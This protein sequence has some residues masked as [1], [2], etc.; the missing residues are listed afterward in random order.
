VH[1]E[2]FTRRLL[3]LGLLCFLSAV[4]ALLG[5]EPL[6]ASDSETV[7]RALDDPRARDLLHCSI[8]PQAPR[9]DFAFRFEVGYIVWCPLASFGGHDSTILI[10][11]RATPDGGKPM[12]LGEGY[13]LPEIDWTTK[14]KDLKQDIQM[15][16]GF[17]V[18]EGQYR[19]EVLVVDNA[20]R[21]MSRKSWRVRVARRGSQR[22]AEVAVAPRSVLPLVARPWPITVDT[23]GKGLRVTVLMDAAPLTRRSPSLRAWDRAFLLGSLS[24]LLKEIPCASVRLRAFNLA[25]Q[26]EVFREDSFDD[27]GFRKL[28]ESLRKVELGKV[29]YQVLQHR[30]GA[31]EMLVDYA[32]E[33][34]TR[35]DPSDV[36]IFFGPAWAYFTDVPRKMLRQR[37]TAYPHFYYFEYFP[38]APRSGQF[39]DAISSLT[40]A[41]NGTVY[42]VY[43]P[44]DFARS[45]QK[46]LAKLQPAP[47][48]PADPHWPAKPA[49]TD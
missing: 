24:S 6:N 46:M 14:P 26:R 23:S 18:G 41:L 3:L 20:T 36:V 47:R 33:E 8:H 13:H 4:P 10:F 45:I 32:N 17:A 27:A 38:F 34:L 48:P 40:K 28:H 19:V 31:L 2:P 29:S 30:R 7:S 11:A 1:S 35:A 42:W 12:L 49:P 9:F 16:G 39:P 5:Q 15:S 43:S 21:R 25:Q 37:E 44:G 22:A